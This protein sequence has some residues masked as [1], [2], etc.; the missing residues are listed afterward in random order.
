M[1]N[2]KKINSIV[3]YTVL[4]LFMAAILFPFF[5][6]LM[7]SLKPSAEAIQYPPT[8]FPKHI[9][10]EHIR[11]IFNPK[12]FPFRSYFSNS[13]SIAL[14]S[15]AV[16]VVAGIFGGYS[17]SKLRFMG[18]TTINQS[19]YFVYMF[20]GILLVVPLFK[21]ISSL[22]LTNTRTALIITMVVQTLPTCVFMLKSYFDTIPPEI[23]EAGTVDGLN[24]VQI[25]YKI[26]VPLSISGIVSVFVYAFMIAWNDYL[27]ASTL[28][29]SSDLFTLPIGLNTLFSTPDYVWGRMMAASLFTSLPIIVLYALSERF[30]KSGS[31]EGGVKG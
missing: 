23:E 30:I 3:F 15:A 12:I 26:I 10:T 29:S 17:L 8:I 11:D 31:T 7:V 14:I 24:K 20:S 13:I 5:I 6:M 16:S 22:G 1:K 19:F 4:I 2:K 28:L 25:V 27:F 21:I 9:T 18:R